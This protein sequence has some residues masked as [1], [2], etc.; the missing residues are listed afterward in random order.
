[1]SKYLFPLIGLLMVFNSNSFAMGNKPSAEK[2]QKL[3]VALKP[4]KNPD[5]MVEQKG[6]LENYLGEHWN[7]P[8]EVMVPLSSSVI[9]EGFRNQSVDLGFLSSVDMVNAVNANIAEVL[10]A[11]DF[12]GKQSY[13]SYWLTLKDKNYK[14]I[15][16]L[17]GK[18]VAFASRTSTSGYLIPHWDLIKSGHLQKGQSPEAFFGKGNVW[19]GSGYVSAIQQV[20]A[21][22]AEAAAVSDYVFETDR[23]LTPEQKAK[24]R[25][26]DTQ[27]PVPSHMLAVRAS[28][29][30]NQKAELKKIFQ[31]LNQSHFEELRNQLFESKLVSVNQEEHLHSTEEALQLTNANM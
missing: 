9:L 29:P 28:L 15:G 2:T 30:E 1:M 25:V 16:E 4:D 20:L 13:Q 14:N 22:N 17:K 6:R 23:Y 21:G 8:V 18:P 10:L 3:V 31:G 27:G 19:Y 26:L 24:L 11:V 5:R 12:N 7:S